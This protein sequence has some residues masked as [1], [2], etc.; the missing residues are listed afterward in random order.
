MS[1]IPTLSRLFNCH[2]APVRIFIPLYCVYYD[3]EKARAARKGVSM[4]NWKNWFQCAAIRAVRTAAQTMVAMLPAS[5]M[6]TDVSWITMLYTA[7]FAAVAS[8][9]TSLAGLPEEE[10]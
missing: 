7:A 5:A 10:I 1:S 6:I 3:G 8:M 2:F 4:R 9:I